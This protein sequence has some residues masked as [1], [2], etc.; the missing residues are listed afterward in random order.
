MILSLIYFLPCIVS[1]LW[2][3]SFS[4]KLKT[5]RQRQYMVSLLFATIFYAIYAIYV[6]PETDYETMAM[7]EPVCIPAGLFCPV[8]LLSCLHIHRTGQSFSH[9]TMFAL[10]VPPIVVGSVVNL[11]YYIIGFDDAALIS[12]AFAQPEG[13]AALPHRLDTALTR[14]YCFCTYNLFVLLAAALLVLVV[15]EIVLIARKDRYRVG[16]V[17]RFFFCGK[18]TTQSRAFAF[19]TLAEVVLILFVIVVGSTMLVRYPLLGGVLTVLVAVAKH[20]ASH[21]EFYAKQNAVVSLYGLSHLVV[22]IDEPATTTT[23]MKD[24]TVA[25]D[26]SVTTVEV[27]SQARATDTDEVPTDHAAVAEHHSH[28]KSVVVV[29]RFV[30]LMVEE[31]LYQRDDLTAETLCDLM[32]VRRTTLSTALNAHFDQPL[33]DI[34]NHYR[35]EEAKRYMLAHPA[36]T[37]EEVAAHCGFRNAQYLNTKFKH[38]VGHTP[39]MWLAEQGVVG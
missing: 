21:V 33:R 13:L 34:I 19:L 12:R 11:L 36:A 23:P 8:Y 7:L 1:L 15:R 18:S 32:G 24:E 9:R 6:F 10:L 16:D 29:E 38:I 4:F 3:V 14:T 30:H 28:H 25:T 31:R 35:I 20:C 2:L 17:F 22:G 26:R 5:Q 39:A 37:Q 27:A